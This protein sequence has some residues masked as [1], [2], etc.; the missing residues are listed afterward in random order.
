MKWRKDEFAPLRGLALRFFI[1]MVIVRHVVWALV[2]E[3]S[4][5]S[6]DG[7]EPMFP[8]ME[9]DIVLDIEQPDASTSFG[10]RTFILITARHTH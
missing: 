2:V 7:M 6:R 9:V 10:F 5:R 4:N 1:W 8:V 3:N